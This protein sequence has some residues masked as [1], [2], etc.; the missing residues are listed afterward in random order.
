VLQRHL[1]DSAEIVDSPG[2]H[3]EQAAFIKMTFKPLA[4]GERA[5]DV[6]V[7]DHGGGSPQQV[8][9]SGTGT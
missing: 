5:A 3:P 8:S 7:Y 4:K 6:S 2:L 9:L 1:E